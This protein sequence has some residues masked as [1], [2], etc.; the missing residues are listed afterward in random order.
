MKSELVKKSFVILLFLSYSFITLSQIIDD[1]TKLVYGPTT[2]VYTYEKYVQEIDSIFFPIDTAIAEFEKFEFVQKSEIAYQNL[3]ANG[4]ALKPVYYQAPET[5]GKT[6]GYESFSPY[7][8]SVED[9]KYYNTRSPFMD[10]DI[11]FG[12]NNRTVVDFSFSRNVNPNLNVGFDIQRLNTDKQIGAEIKIGD[13]NVLST[14]ADIYT[15]YASENKKYTLLFHALKFTHKVQETGGIKEDDFTDERL[16]YQYLD[17]EI[18]L[19]S[20]GVEDV[21]TRYHIFQQYSLKPFFQLYYIF[22]KIKQENTFIDQSLSSAAEFY[23][24]SRLINSDT[25]FEISNFDEIKNQV[26]IKGKFSSK[27][28]YNAYLK[29]RDLDFSHNNSGNFGHISENYIG[30]KLKYIHNQNN[31]LEGSFEI[32]PSGEYFFRGEL[33]NKYIQ[34]SYSSSVYK[35]SYLV[36][37]YSGNHYDW[38]NSFKSTFV[39]TIEGSMSFDFELISLKPKVSISS[40]DDY[41][42]FDR[43]QLPAQADLAIINNY[44]LSANVRLKNNLRFDNNIVFNNV[45]GDGADAF[46]IPTWSVNGRWYYDGFGFNNYMQF[47]LGVNVH[48]QSGFFA[49]SYNPITQQFYLQDDFKV[50]SYFVAD[51]FLAFKLKKARIFAKVTH[52]NQP[53]EGGYMA[54]PFYSGQQRVFDLGLRWLFFD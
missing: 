19:R 42:Y 33:N 15:Y 13:N 32:L 38:T 49:K 40:V 43:A 20:A 17:S 6:T 12:G 4:T 11:G 47:Q 39:N 37:R 9:F 23:P 24:E 14:T 53:T 48:W 26:G 46:R 51:V 25:T 45:S 22:D 3:G 50:D 16:L 21:R 2:S 10:L 35:P 1:S 30:G 44:S 31:D 29:R 52:V 34:A 28:F 18:Q 8:K 36:D 27:L 5:I 41:I 54:T 7:F